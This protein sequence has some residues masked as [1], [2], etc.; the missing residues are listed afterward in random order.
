VF[1]VGT[2]QAMSVV[3]LYELCRHTAG[4]DAEAR[5]EAERPGDLRHSLLDVSR[6]ERELAWRPEV[7]LQDG[8][9]RTWESLA[10]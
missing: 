4:S 2:G 9:R 10:R 6:A 1:N 3:E 7:S 8:L 5:F